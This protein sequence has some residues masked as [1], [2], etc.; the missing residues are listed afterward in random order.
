MSGLFKDQQ[1]KDTVARLELRDSRGP[2][3]KGPYR[4]L[5]GLRILS[6]RARGR[7]AR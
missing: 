2:D 3:N 7:V 4:S 6:G 1:G 5:S